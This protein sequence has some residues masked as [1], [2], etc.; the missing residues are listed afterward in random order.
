MSD[1]SITLHRDGG[2]THA[3]LDA[4]RRVRAISTRSAIALHRKCGLIPTR[5]MTITRLL[6]VAT[7]FTGKPY[8]GAGKH[9]RAEADL[10]VWIDT[11]TAALPIIDE[12][13]AA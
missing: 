7:E 6:A 8:K 3:G 5:G 9:E 1:S 12:R 10:T 4:V 11:M 2:S 13:G